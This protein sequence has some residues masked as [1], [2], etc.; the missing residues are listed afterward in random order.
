MAQRGAFI[1]LISTHM[2]IHIFCQDKQE[3]DH[4]AEFEFDS[5]LVNT[6][7]AKQCH[8]EFSCTVGTN[9]HTSTLVHKFFERVRWQRFYWCFL[10]LDSRKQS[11]LRIANEAFCRQLIKI[12]PLH[13]KLKALY[14]RGQNDPSDPKRETVCVI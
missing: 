13:I 7:P 8:K 2:Y 10:A 9:D 4:D 1:D 6:A 3:V 14:Y 11:L 5:L 12:Y